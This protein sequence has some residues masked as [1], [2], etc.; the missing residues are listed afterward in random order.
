VAA[1]HSSLSETAA[2]ARAPRGCTAL[3]D[4]W[5]LR[6]APPLRSDGPPTCRR[7]VPLAAP[8]NHGRVGAARL[9]PAT[10]SACHP[11][12]DAS[13]RRRV[14][15]PL[16]DVLPR[17]RGRTFF[18]TDAA[19]SV[20]IRI[21]TAQN[22]VAHYPRPLRPPRWMPDGYQRRLR[23][24]GSPWSMVASGDRDGVGLSL[25]GVGKS[26]GHVLIH[27]TFAEYATPALVPCASAAA[28]AGDC[29]R[30]ADAAR[31]RQCC[32]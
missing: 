2:V 11:S 28:M 18:S 23:A 25:R 4:G 32:A 20:R 17:R 26:H 31:D 24:T 29:G 5:R 30:S 22:V 7:A 12:T 6:Q 8:P 13:R 15:L 3:R 27:R 14:P 21:A 10:L 9:S 16:D 1:M 19:H